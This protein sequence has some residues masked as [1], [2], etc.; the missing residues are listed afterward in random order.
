[1]PKK[2]KIIKVYS[3]DSTIPAFGKGLFAQTNITKGSI[4]V[5]FKGKLRHPDEQ[6]TSSRS[7][8]YFNDEYVLECPQNDL[9]S[10]ANDAINFTGTRRKLMKSLHSDQP[11]YTKH[12]NT[13][14]NATIKINDNLHRA[15]LIATENISANE[16]IFCHYGFIYWFKQEITISGFIEED[17][18]EENGF[19]E[20]IFEYPA[21][22]SYIKHFYPDYVSHEIKPFRDTFDFIIHLSDGQCVIV[23]MENF[24]K[25]IQTV[26]VDNFNREMV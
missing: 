8:I 4:I 11:F 12:P 23:N 7:N 26:S 6:T 3:K 24:S 21:F 13:K 14:I 9:A 17:E 19:P 10:F 2:S 15:F 16:E 22:L 1:M 20:K 25:K 18:I 5:E